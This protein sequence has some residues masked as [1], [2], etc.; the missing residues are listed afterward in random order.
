MAAQTASH[1][2]L[3]FLWL[4]VTGR[5]S[6]RC[7]HCYAS[8]GAHG[9]HGTMTAA[10]WHRLLDEAAGLGVRDVQFIGGEPTL[11]PAL[12][13]LVRH[14]LDRGLTVE[15][16]SNL[17]RVTDPLW[18]MFE[19][20]GV[21]LATSYYSP[22]AGQHDAITGRRSHDRTLANICEALR[23]GVPL[24]VGITAVGE[25]Q[26]VD[27]AVAELGTLGVEQITVDVLRQVGRGVRD[28][29]P[30]A[31]QLCGHCT[32]GTLAVS[33]AGEVWPCPL[34]RWLV[35]GNVRDMSLADLRGRAAP[36]REALSREF[37][38]LGRSGGRKCPPDDADPC[39]GPLCPPHLTCGPDEK[40][41]RRT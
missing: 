15:I 1:E 4:E 35:I 10:D 22:D 19:Q 23:R 6:L 41:S 25:N 3:S 14:A 18:D 13:D 21:R 8:S 36:V 11:Y 39:G 12:S 16:Y 37:V 30:S 31:R 24:R 28:A 9:T 33:P 2:A 20:P 32:D 27:G 38:R 5:C 7:E 29:A 26:D 17:V 34:S 40:R